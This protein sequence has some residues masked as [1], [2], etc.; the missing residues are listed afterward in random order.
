MDKFE[1][2]GLTREAGC[3]VACPS[4]A[5]SPLSLEC[6]VFDIVPLGTHDMFLAD[7]LGVRVDESLL[8]ASGR[9]CLE[10]AELAAFAH[11]EYFALGRRLEKFGFSAVKSKRKK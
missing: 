4:I 7:V 11:G 2:C 6:R 5:Q 10:R 3:T 8:D 9:L 1:R